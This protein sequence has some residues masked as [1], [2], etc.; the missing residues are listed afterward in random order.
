MN[1][2]QELDKYNLSEEK[3][4]KLLDAC[5]GKVN[6]EHDM[7][8]S[9]INL[10]YGLGWNPDSLRKASTSILGGAFVKQ[11]IEEKK[12]AGSASVLVETERKLEEL[13]R[14]RMKIQ[15]LNIERNRV[16]REAARQELFYEYVGSAIT[17]FTPPVFEPPVFESLKEND[18]KTTYVLTLADIHYG[19]EF[20]SERN[21]YSPAV[22][23]ERMIFALEDT[24]R[25][26][27][28]KQLSSLKVVNLGDTIQGMLRVS[29]IK[30]NESS[31][32][33]S[34][35]DVSNLLA[36]FLNELSV[37]VEVDYYH[38]PKANH[39]QLRPLGTKAGA[40]PEEDLEYV[41][42]HYIQALCKDN[43][44]I[45]INL[46][47]DNS[48]YIK[49][50]IPGF[51]VYAKHGHDIKNVNNSLKDFE[52]LINE[53]V[54]YLFI[55]HYH[56]NDIVSGSEKVTYDSEI[57]VSPSFI[58]SCPYSDTLYKG[59]KAAFKIY[60]FSEI[61]GHTETYKFILN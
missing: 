35:V 22:A 2:K 49:V 36:W 57:L 15:T 32:V 54:D 44:R 1:I 3:Y 48:T 8:W 16:D 34:V 41:I 4:E 50:E 18:V 19:A 47:E 27:K 30:L 43:D 20:T 58:G 40:L 56:S 17:P 38:V 39:S 51:A 10:R 45:W 11:Y 23:R 9:E 7:D 52:A 5:Y 13:R 6:H 37:Y 59:N 46:Q 33:K 25:F 21:K 55:G 29:D 42:G 60:G 26:I 28:D 14:E 12:V 24:I 31:V 61:Y 53:N